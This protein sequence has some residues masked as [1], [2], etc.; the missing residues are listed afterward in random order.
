MP[1]LHGQFSHTYLQKTPHS[2]P[3]RARYAVSFV[4]PASDWY[5]ASVSVIIYVIFHNIR[6]HSAVTENADISCVL[7]TN[8][9]LQ[10]LR[11]Q[12]SNQ[13]ISCDRVIPSHPWWVVFQ[14]PISKWANGC[15]I[16]DKECRKIDYIHE[17]PRNL[18]KCLENAWKLLT[19]LEVYNKITNS[20]FEIY[21][22]CYARGNIWA[23]YNQW[24]SDEFKFGM[25]VKLGWM[26]F[27]AS[28][29]VIMI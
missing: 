8:S 3:V 12:N 14:S 5:I 18:K 26:H 22:K 1:L 10:V 23:I 21:K 27:C 4:D 24:N 11:S 29:T 20:L 25:Y 7:K 28:E 15:V 2:S 19:V 16:Y 9:A 17:W 6:Q 13:N